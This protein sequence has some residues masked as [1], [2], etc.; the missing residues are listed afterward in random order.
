[1]TK[2]EQVRYFL[3]NIAQ[4]IFSRLGYDRTT[5]EII[6][7]E[8]GKGKSTLY[9]Y[10]KNKEEIF[11]AVIEQQGKKIQNELLKI[12]NQ[13]IDTRKLL[14][15]YVLKRYQL[16]NELI[17]YYNVLKDDYLRNMPLVEK[18]R[19]QH[20]EF[21]FMAIKNI[22]IKGIDREEIGID[23]HKIDDVAMAIAVA[24]K[25]LEIPVFFDHGIREFESK[26]DMLI[27]VLF[28]GIAKK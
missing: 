21:E 17:N 26:I 19:K 10:F 2:K 24:I 22:L 5:M 7:R 4:R 27:D 12:I 28:D 6:A 11:A 14:K 8:A 13:N 18:Y 20:D 23:E 15:K 3:I 25:G 1:M 9:Y 16:V